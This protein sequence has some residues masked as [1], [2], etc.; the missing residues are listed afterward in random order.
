MTPVTHARDQSIAVVGLGGSG[1]ATAR[2]LIAGGAHAF[3]WDDSEAQRARALQEGITIAAIADMPWQDIRSLILAPGIPLTH[4]DGIRYTHEA[5]AMARAHQIEVI[6]DIELFCRERA[7]LA[8]DAP[9]I[10]IT[11]TNGKSTTTA[12]IAHIL[13]HSGRDVQMGGNIGAAILSLAPPSD[14]RIHVVEVSSFQVDLAPG[15]EP[16]VS[17]FL[18]LTPDHLDRHGTIADYWGIKHQM[19]VNGRY[20]VV[21]IDDSWGKRTAAAID[22]GRLATV[23]TRET[24]DFQWRDGQIFQGNEC[25]AS[26]A[27][28]GS[29]RGEHNGQNA[30]AAVAACLRIGCS[31]A[32]IQEGLR[33]F[34]G[35]AHRMEMVGKLG[36]VL[37]VNDSKAT[38]A[39]STEKALTSFPGDIYWIVGGKAKDGGIEPLAA[40]FPRVAK[41]YL[42]GASRM[43]FAETLEGRVP[44]NL[45]DT[46]DVAI[47]QAASDAAESKGPEPIVLLSPACASYDQFANFE[48]RGD[49]F[50]Q[51]ARTII[52]G[53][54]EPMRRD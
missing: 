35:L 40:C 16:D 30:S 41:A 20:A 36:K 46:L 53:S 45:S 8:P 24:A 54:S 49:Y 51:L 47:A 9:F 34:P 31:L 19:T 23:S 38:N 13:Q 22:A 11:G 52:D 12:L 37:F 39:D 48:V 32:E 21:G 4:K 44:Y 28:I 7:K 10:A 42:I 27:G 1:L 5:V 14:R 29:L 15:L 26:V 25:V 50:R 2:A 6:G 18:N 3:A 43:A 33:T 17:V